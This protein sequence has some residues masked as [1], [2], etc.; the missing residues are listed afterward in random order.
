MGFKKGQSGNP[1]T[2]FKPGQSGNPS[3]NPKGYVQTRTLMREM[4]EGEINWDE[5]PIRGSQQMEQKYGKRVMRAII[6]VAI[7]KA[8]E[9]DPAARRW[10]TETLY[11]KNI[12]VTSDNKPLP[13]PIYNGEAAK[14]IGKPDPVN[15]VNTDEDDD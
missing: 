12:D 2:Q 15:G 6:A 10:L 14:T 13:T 8:L 3:G 7:A 1:A 5:I 11:G 9:G 4:L